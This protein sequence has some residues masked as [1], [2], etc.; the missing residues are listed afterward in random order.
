M[1][2]SICLVA[3]A[4]LFQLAT[5]HFW[6]PPPPQQSFHESPSEVI[7]TFVRPNGIH[8]PQQAQAQASF[9]PSRVW[10]SDGVFLFRPLSA[11]NGGPDSR[12]RLHSPLMERLASSPFGKPR[13]SRFYKDG[14]H[15]ENGKR[16]R[17]FRGIK[18]EINVK[19]AVL[20]IWE[21]ADGGEMLRRGSREAFLT[22]RRRYFPEMPSSERRPFSEGNYQ[23]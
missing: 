23:P 15:E 9:Q 20:P 16:R 22:S 3:W 8:T 11:M 14:N 12:L 10:K 7:E 5:A 4:T 18:G 13:F 6:L 2:V 17:Q 1:K 21:H 19:W